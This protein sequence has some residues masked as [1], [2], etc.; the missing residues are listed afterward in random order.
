M[1]P[2]TLETL[3][4]HLPSPP[5]LPSPCSGHSS[6]SALPACEA[7]PSLLCHP[8]HFPS[9]LGQALHPD[10]T[11]PGLSS[12]YSQLSSAFLL[13]FL[14]PWQHHSLISSAILFISGSCSC[15]PLPISPGCSLWS[16]FH[17]AHLPTLPQSCLPAACLSPMLPAQYCLF[18]FWAL[19]QKY[20]P[21]QAACAAGQIS[22]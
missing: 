18:L 7:A 19:G 10:T 1:S 20:L 8:T 2:I 13:L 17:L 22:S 11:N 3:H 21:S 4:W 5:H 12:L 14:S 9:T 15:L 16:C 6:A